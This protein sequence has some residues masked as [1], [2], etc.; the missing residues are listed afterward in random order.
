MNSE[1]IE[2]GRR[3][4]SFDD[5]DGEGGPREEDEGWLAIC[6]LLIPLRPCEGNRLIL[7]A[8]ANEVTF[9][10]EL[11]DGDKS[12]ESRFVVCT[13]RPVIRK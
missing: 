13:F 8:D 1:S 11:T 4:E 9:V 2:C 10:G 12:R 7:P 3:G 6:D 5:V